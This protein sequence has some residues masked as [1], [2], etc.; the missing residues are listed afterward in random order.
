MAA[1]ALR[2]HLGWLAQTYARPVELSIASGYFNPEGFGL[3]A[4]E[5]QRLPRMRLLCG[6]EPTP[7]SARPQRRL[8]ESSQSYN[9]GVVRE[10]IEQNT[11]GLLHNRDLLAFSPEPDAAVRRL[12]RVTE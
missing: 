3:L 10:G 4:D 8:G 6:A 2:G 12:E 1:A 5:L 11:K 9:A 7:P